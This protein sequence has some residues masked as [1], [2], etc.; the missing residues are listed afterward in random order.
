MTQIPRRSVLKSTGT[1]AGTALLATSSFPAVAQSD[2][3]TNDDSTDTETTQAW[4]M[5]RGNPSR[6]GFSD[7]DDVGP[8]VKTRFSV[9]DSNNPSGP[10]ELTVGDGLVIAT[11]RLD[12]VTGRNAIVAYDAATG[13]E[14]WTHEPPS[15]AGET[16]D[17]GVGRIPDP[18]VVD[19]GTVYVA[20]TGAN[21]DGEW[22]Y[23]GLFAFDA[24]TGYIE[25]LERDTLHWR[26]PLLVDGTL[27][28]QNLRNDNV[29]AFDADDGSRL[30]ELDL[31]LTTSSL[32]AADED[33][34]YAR[35]QV[36]GAPSVGGFALDDGTQK[37]R[38]QL[39]DDVAAD[40]RT[41]STSDATVGDATIYY[42][43]QTDDENAL[44]AQSLDDGSVRWNCTLTRNCGD[45]QETLS[46]PV[47][48]DGSVYAST[49]LDPSEDASL[50]AFLWSVDAE[51]GETEW[52]W[53]S[54]YHLYG[55]PTATDGQ[56][57]LGTE[58]PLTEE[59][60]ERYYDVEPVSGYPTVVAIDSDDGDV[61][62]AYAEPPESGGE[63]ELVARTPVPTDRGIYVE[64]TGDGR[65]SPTKVLSLAAT[66]SEIGPNHRPA[67][68]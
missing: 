46:K 61:S 44:V 53:S 23:G 26:D 66:E 5:Y 63:D 22:A 35:L 29:A 67:E 24:E 30:W 57:Y 2:E 43:T 64:A 60:S 65:D 45:P 62:W 13:E 56:V 7:A 17:S 34:V 54:P 42:A 68:L 15:R 31:E 47:L 16:P 49:S 14:Q 10:A 3:E 39:P 8:A 25:W 55:S 27:V 40:Q 6:T 28:V 33:T 48:A 41:I 12:G 59:A 11:E 58:A 52:V 51:T 18:P 36:P 9:G 19:D 20:S 21:D 4:P 1:I 37:W 50:P 38:H 32:L